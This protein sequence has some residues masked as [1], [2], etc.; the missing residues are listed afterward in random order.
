MDE[1]LVGVDL[2]ITGEGCIDDQTPHGK[3]VSGV[4]RRAQHA[5]A[6]VVAVAGRCTLDQPGSRMPDVNRIAALMDQAG[7]TMERSMGQTAV[8]LEEMVVGV[9]IAGSL[10]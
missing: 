7:M 3:V 5:G 8:E 4:A 9:L 6:K 1:L 2:V 10:R